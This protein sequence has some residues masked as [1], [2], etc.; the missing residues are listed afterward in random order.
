MC[1]DAIS[2]SELILV[3][4]F[5]ADNV[6]H[7]LFWVLDQLCGRSRQWT[8]GAAISWLIDFRLIVG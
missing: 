5:R 8:I 4:V 1:Y 3:L 7:K 2:V 6:C